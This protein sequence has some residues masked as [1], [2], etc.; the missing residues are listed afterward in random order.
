MKKLLTLIL[1]MFIG[2]AL[3]GCGNEPPKEGAN[4]AQTDAEQQSKAPEM[5]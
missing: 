1:A 3:I 4:Q 5:Q 2:A